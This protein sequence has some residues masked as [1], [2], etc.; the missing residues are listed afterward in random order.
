MVGPI[1]VMAT[2]EEIDA[3]RA[4]DSDAAAAAF[5]ERFWERRDPAAD[6]PGN[7]LRERFES[8]AEVADRRY[9][10]A[11]YLGRRTARGTVFVLYG[12]PDAVEYESP[13]RPGSEPIE[14]W[15]YDEDR[16]PGLDGRAPE[17]WYRFVKDGDLTV[18]YRGP[19]VPGAPARERF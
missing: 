7:P 13:R 3:Y 2:P 4:L 15:S 12:E 1:A 17:R 6:R 9:A 18:F 14:V 11:G 10:E 8:R 5:V 16:E 19:G